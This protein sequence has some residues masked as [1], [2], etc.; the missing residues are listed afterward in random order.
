MN[1]QKF[2]CIRGYMKSG[3]NWLGR[4]LNCHADICCIGEFHWH[5]FFQALNAN[6]V[7][8]APKRRQW[9]ENTV[10]LQ[11]HDMVRKSLV[12]LADTKAEWIGD[13]TPTTLAPVVIPEA[14][15]FI[16]VRDFRDVIVSRMFHLYNHPRVTTLFDRIPSLRQGLENFQR[17]PWFFHE[18]PDQ[19]LRCEEVVRDSA[20]EWKAFLEADRETIQNVPGLNV[21]QVQ[22]EQLHRQFEPIVEKIFGFLGLSVPT[23]DP[24]VLPGQTKE[25]PNALRR[26]GQV[27]DWRN[28]IDATIKQWINEEV[29]DD[30]Q[31]LG[32][33]D[34]LDW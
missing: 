16:M 20:R 30:L 10:G 8:I 1:T 28:Y 5:T 19:L 15:H 23:M 3:T 24:A 33:V 12:A 21:M 31:R 14:H 2:L 13:R 9:L 25:D 26:K 18:F 32:Y 17:D 11:L 29:F 34:S 7:R 6:V 4:V 27:G 22:Y